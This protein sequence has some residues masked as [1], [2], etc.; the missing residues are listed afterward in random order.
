MPRN[1]LNDVIYAQNNKAIFTAFNNG[2]L[3]M[4]Y[5]DCVLQTKVLFTTLVT[6]KL[7]LRSNTWASRA[8]PLTPLGELTAFPQTP[9]SIN[10][11]YF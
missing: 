3:S 4:L 1:V 8:L 7:K 6:F 9:S 5:Y 2:F 11:P 10:G